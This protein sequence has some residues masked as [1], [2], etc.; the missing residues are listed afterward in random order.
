MSTNDV[1]ESVS[2]SHEDTTNE[3]VEPTEV[4][5]RIGRVVKPVARLDL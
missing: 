5:T 4:K 1:N 3:N 2:V